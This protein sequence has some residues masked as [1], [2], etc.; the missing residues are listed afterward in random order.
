MMREMKRVRER[1][2]FVH[3]VCMIAEFDEDPRHLNDIPEVIALCRRLVSLGF[4]SYLDFS[5]LLDPEHSDRLGLAWGAV[6]VWM[7]AERKAPGGS[8]EFTREL[9]EEFKQA[10]H[11]SNAIAEASVGKY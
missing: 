4:I 6:E 8:Y 11:R 3:I 9:V 10:L 5:T 2:A 7:C 1:G